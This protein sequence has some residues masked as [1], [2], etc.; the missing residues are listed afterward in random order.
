MKTDP[1]HSLQEKKH[2]FTLQIRRQRCIYTLLG[3]EDVWGVT[4]N[5]AYTQIPP[6]L[7]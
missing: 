3:T 4:G 1:D 2:K 6:F 7:P 5:N